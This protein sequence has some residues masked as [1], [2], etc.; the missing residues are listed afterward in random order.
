M[1]EG[2]RVAEFPQ[3]TALQQPLRQRLGGQRGVGRQ[4]ARDQLAQHLLRESCRRRIH[5]RQPVGQRGAEL[6]DAELRMDH[7]ATEMPFAHLAEHAHAAA[8]GERFLLIRI[9]VEE[10]QARAARGPPASIGG[11]LQQ[12]HELTTRPVLDV[13]RDDRSF[14][15]LLDCRA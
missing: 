12:T 10:A 4:H 6:D 15:L 3:L 5:R 7:L 14:R 11:I 1:E 13:R 9:E 8:G 2:E